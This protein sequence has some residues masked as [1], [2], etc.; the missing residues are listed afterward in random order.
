MFYI[1]TPNNDISYLQ[2]LCSDLAKLVNEYPD[3]PI[4]IA[5]DLNLPNINWD[6]NSVDFLNTFG[7]YTQLILLLG[8]VIPWIFSVQIDHLL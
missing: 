4:W 3:V 5:G 8:L 2:C 6:N 1:Q 7:L